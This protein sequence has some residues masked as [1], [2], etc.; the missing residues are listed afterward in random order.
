MG[1][2]CASN[3]CTTEPV[4][5]TSF[6]DCEPILR[7]YGFA[8]FILHKCNWTPANIS[9]PTE[10]EAAIADGTVQC[11]PPGKMTI[12][13]PTQTL[14]EWDGCGT[15]IPVDIEYLLDWESFAT[16]EDLADYGYYKTLFAEAQ[17]LRLIPKDC[18][19]TFFLCDEWIQAVA[20][21]TNTVAN[22][23]PGYEF[24]ISQLPYII[25]DS[26][27]VKWAA[28]FKIKISGILCPT[29]LPGVADVLCCN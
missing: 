18:N 21:A 27:Q 11:S 23:T 12:Q 15:E 1:V 26:G 7:K 22:S 28:Q 24:S 8:S 5:P 4:V 13:Q 14:I 17:N 20:D 10:W 2:I 29:Y 3:C 16:S 9:D 19:N 25:E 6:Y